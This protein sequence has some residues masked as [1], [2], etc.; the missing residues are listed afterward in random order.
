MCER[1]EEGGRR[2]E[3]KKRKKKTVFPSSL[4]FILS[5]PLLFKMSRTLQRAVVLESHHQRHIPI[6]SSLA[7]SQQKAA[8]IK[9]EEEEEFNGSPSLSF[10]QESP[11]L[12]S[13]RVQNR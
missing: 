1:E 6:Y 11:V 7:H 4:S 9:E 2:K 8:L 3:K 13:R 5:F 12:S 10:F